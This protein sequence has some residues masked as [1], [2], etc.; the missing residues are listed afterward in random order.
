MPYRRVRV[1]DDVNQQ[2]NF[3]AVA[4]IVQ[5]IG[6]Q[7]ERPNVVDPT[8]VRNYYARLNMTKATSWHENGQLQTEFA[9]NKSWYDLLEPVDKAR[10][11]M[12]ATTINAYY[13]PNHN[14]I[15]FP[16]G[17]M[18][19]PIFSSEVPEY[20]SYGAWGMVV[21]HELTHAFDN[22][23][24]KF[25]MNG[26]LKEWWDE[27]TK[28]NF[29]PRTK[30]FEKQFEQFTVPGLDNEPVHVNGKLTE[31]ENIA[32][33]GGLVA[34]Y[35]AWKEREAAKMNLKL[36]GFESFTNDQMFFLSAAFWKCGKDRKESLLAQVYTDPH[37]PDNV[38]TLGSSANSEAFRKAFNCPVKQPTCALW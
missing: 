8:D 31:G 30:C 20:I 1:I 29:E 10:W 32:D 15:V 17:I 14:E 12:T 11:A 28:K 24:S 9:A 22:H 26:V 19:K 36:P 18:G 5:K 16:A 7:T 2:A 23:G 33:T 13:S 27:P 3:T 21:G 38:R 37:S 35:Q 4:N 34:A 6:Y 25:D